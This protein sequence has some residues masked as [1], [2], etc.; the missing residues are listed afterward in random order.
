MKW[1]LAAALTSWSSASVMKSMNMISSTG[2][3]PDWAAPIATPVMAASLI[4]VS[5][6][7]PAL[8][9]SARPAVAVYGPPSATSSPSTNTRGS[10]RIALAS[11]DV[12]ALTYVV[13]AIG[14]HH[15]LQQADRREGT[16]AREANGGLDRRRRAG[17][18]GG[19]GV[20][21]EPAL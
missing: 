12:M 4:G 18:D 20:L 15:L 7:R 5:I 16:R 2:R 9:S 1:A 8:N 17:L 3:M 10:A 6:A 13:S 21:R 11:D 19:Q 14:V